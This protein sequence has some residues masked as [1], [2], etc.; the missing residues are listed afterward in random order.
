MKQKFKEEMQMGNKKSKASKRQ[1]Q[2]EERD[3]LDYERHLEVYASQNKQ[4]VLN[5]QNF[6]TMV[7]FG[8]PYEYVKECLE[9]NLSNY[10][11]TGYYL[12]EI[13]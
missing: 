4:H 7:Q 12:L 8:Y 9:K 10:C 5:E 6:M 1:Y 11:S 3:E 2:D 13:D